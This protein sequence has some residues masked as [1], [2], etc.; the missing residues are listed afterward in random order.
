M[1]RASILF[2]ISLLFMWNQDY[3]SAQHPALQAKLHQDSCE[4]HVRFLAQPEL[5]GRSPMS[6]G[7]LRA[8]RH[9]VETFERLGLQ[10]WKDERGFTQSIRFGANVVGILPGKDPQMSGQIIL[11]SAHYDHVGD[12]KLGAADDASGVGALLEIASRFA[13]AAEGPKR[14]LCFA[15]FDCEEMGLFGSTAFTCRK[16]FNAANIAAA[17]NLDILGRRGFDCMDNSLF[18]GKTHTSS[19]LYSTAAQA[20]QNAGLRLL[21]YHALLVGPRGDHVPFAALGIPALFFSTGPFKD[22]HTKEDT[23]QNMNWELLHQSCDT[24]Y[25]TVRWIAETPTP[26]FGAKES[27]GSKD[28]LQALRQIVNALPQN[29]RAAQEHLAV[30]EKTVNEALGSD[31]FNRSMAYNI[32]PEVSLAMGSQMD[33]LTGVSLKSRND[34]EKAEYFYRNFIQLLFFEKHSSDIMEMYRQILEKDPIKRT[35]PVQEPEPESFITHG[36]R[37]RADFE[38]CRNPLQEEEISLVPLN[39]GQYHLGV[40]IPVIQ[41]RI[42]QKYI[43]P[44]KVNIDMGWIPYACRGDIDTLIDYCFLMWKTPNFQAQINI[45]TETPDWSPAWKQVLEQV[46]LDMPKFDSMKA[47]FNYRIQKAGYKDENQWKKSVLSRNNPDIMRTLLPFTLN[48]SRE[49]LLDRT[50]PSDLRANELT[51]YFIRDTKEEGILFTKQMIQDL[52]ALTSDQTPILTDLD[53]TPDL[54]PSMELAISINKVRS[55]SKETEKCPKQTIGEV[56]QKRL[57]EIA[58][59]L[60][61]KDLTEYTEDIYV[62]AGIKLSCFPAGTM[63]IVKNRSKKQLWLCKMEAMQGYRVW[64]FITSY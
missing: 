54:P 26:I 20:A 21:S 45:K 12:G 25:D 55:L 35:A 47:A 30:V 10:P 52:N 15:V 32:L 39:N 64:S 28:D 13:H 16:D 43:G 51:Y 29:D 18:L 6:G 61:K 2:S 22:Y 50:V 7:S 9:I 5:N 11:L 1:K 41:A 46:A 56:A 23:I 57:S 4:K 38:A 24:V 62:P 36:K 42:W 53:T 63:T 31:T 37:H 49:I 59:Y 19:S 48:P 27:I 17:V 3:A 60:G 14:T 58:V 40:L 44:P 33:L 8:R 34:T